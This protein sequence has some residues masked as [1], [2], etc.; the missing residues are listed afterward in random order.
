MSATFILKKEPPKNTNLYFLLK[1]LYFVMGG[2]INMNVGLFWETSVG[3]LK[4]IVSHN[5]S[6]G[7]TKVMSIRIS[8]IAQN[9]TILKRIEGMF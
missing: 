2:A 3:F 4:S 5:F 7:M 9:S 1:G 8:N 6:Q